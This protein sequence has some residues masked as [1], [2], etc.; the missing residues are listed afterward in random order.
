[1]IVAFLILFVVSMAHVVAAAVL[2]RQNQLLHRQ[3]LRVTAK[4]TQPHAVV[5]E[6]A[7]SPRRKSE[8]AAEREKKL[9]DSRRALWRV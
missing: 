4:S 6:V 7:P 5:Q 8:A 3:V 1:M 2:W 9:V